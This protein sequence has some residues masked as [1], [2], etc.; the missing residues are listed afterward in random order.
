MCLAG[1]SWSFDVGASRLKEFCGLSVSD[2]HLRA[3]CQRQANQMAQWQRDA[4]EASQ[5]FRQ[6]QGEVEFTTDGTSVNTWEGWREMRL[7]IFA[8]RRCGL[9]A[10]AEQW[11]ERQ[12]P[13]AEARVA[14]AAI[15]KSDRFGSRWSRWRQRLGI[16]DTSRIS[17][18]ADGA[19][20]IWEESSMHFAGASEVL[21]IYHALEHVADTANVLHG[22]GTTAAQAW[23][24]ACRHDLLSG[25]WPSIQQRLD[26]TKAA[27]RRTTHRHSLQRLTAYLEHNQTRLNYLQ[28]LQEGRAIGSGQAEGACKHMIARRLKQTGA[29]WRVRRVNRMAALCCLMYSDHWD[30][31]W[32]KN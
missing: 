14:F 32:A 5:P 30:P 12:L 15:E 18:L 31:Y 28:R 13:S 29:R 10:T 24:D 11:A 1:A 3:I 21:D 20:W 23:S 8:K 26:D 16:R 2:N 19:R 9:P 25:G 17:V 7:G 22:E 27:I 4:T 6:A